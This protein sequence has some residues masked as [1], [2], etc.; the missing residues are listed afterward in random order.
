M[1]VPAV[2]T[3]V[4]DAI[5]PMLE[6]AGLGGFGVQPVWVNQAGGW[7]VAVLGPDRR[8]RW[9]AKW[10]PLS[11]GESL[12]RERE[13]LTWL[14]PRH[15]VPETVGYDCDEAQELLITRAVAGRSAVSPRWRRRPDVALAALGRGLRRLHQLSIEDCPFE[16]STETRLAGRDAADLL[17]ADE[18]SIDRLVVCQGDPCAPNTL[19]AEDGG[20][21]AHV[22]VGRLGI[23]DR[24][25]DLAVMTMSMSWNYPTFDESVFWSA[26]GVEPDPLRIDFYRRLWQAEDQD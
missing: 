3:P 11:S 18:P 12:A 2:G 9:Y 1:S 17:G 19:L 25:A 6:Q 24:W 14:Q 22:D 10:N 8:P 5:E 26:Y 4:P 21:L 16:W 20:F 23:A 13:R 7:T 15:P